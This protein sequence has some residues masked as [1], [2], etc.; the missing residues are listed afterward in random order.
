MARFPYH[1][2]NI[3]SLGK[4]I[5]KAAEDKNFLSEF[6]NNPAKTL[7]SIN[8]PQQ[9]VDLIEF[10]IVDRSKFPR[11]VAVPFKLNDKKIQD[12]NPEYLSSLTQTFALN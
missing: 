2:H 11:A 3:K 6:R 1:Q 10:K 12:G 5:A 4:L 7:A 9:T 8:L